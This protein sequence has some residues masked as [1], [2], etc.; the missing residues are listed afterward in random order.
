MSMVQ[1]RVQDFKVKRSRHIIEGRKFDYNYE[2]LA[3]P[4]RKALTIGQIKILK[5]EK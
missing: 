3:T 2:L 1:E 4:Q 5:G